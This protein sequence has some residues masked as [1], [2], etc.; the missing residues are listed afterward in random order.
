MVLWGRDGVI[1]RC[2]DPLREWSRLADDV[3]GEALD[4]GHY[5]AEEAP[6]LLLDRVLPFL[7]GQRLANPAH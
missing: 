6:Q 3:C 2:F 1:Q 7:D 5:I 4:C